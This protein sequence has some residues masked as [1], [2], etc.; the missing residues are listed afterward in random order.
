MLTSTGRKLGTILAAAIVTALVVAGCGGSDPAPTLAPIIVVPTA[1]TA[2]TAAPQIVIEKGEAPAAPKATPTPRI[3]TQLPT[4][5]PTPGLGSVT[6]VLKGFRWVQGPGVDSWR[7]A[8]KRGGTHTYAFPY[9]SGGT[10]QILSRSFTVA[11]AISSVYN[12]L[13]T[14]Q[15]SPLMVEGDP[16]NCFPVG[17]LISEWESNS[18]GTAWTLT[19]HP[20][21]KW[22]NFPE[23][24]RGYDAALTDLYGRDV[25]AADV[26]H[27]VHYMQGKLTKPN[28]EPQGTASSLQ[29]T[30][31]TAS[32]DVVDDKTV[33]FNLSSADPFFTSTW[34]EFNTK[35]M[36]PEIFNLDG[37]YTQRTVGS[38]PF[39]LTEWDRMVQWGGPANPNYHKVGA[40]GQSLP[41]IDR[42]QVKRLG[43]DLAISGFITGQVDNA[44]GVGVSGPSSALTFGR[45]CPNCQILEYF[46]SANTSRILG[47]KHTAT[48]RYP[49]PY[50][51]DRNARLAVAK[52]ID[53]KGIG[54]NLFEGAWVMTPVGLAWG[55]MWDQAA[56]PSLKQMGL[57]LPDD[58]NPFIYDPEK[59]KELWAQA[60]KSP[61]EKIQLMYHEYSATHT[62]YT[63]A[64]GASIAEALDI[65]VDV[66]KVPDISILYTATG[67]VDP[68]NQQN[69]EHLVTHTRSAG[70][71]NGVVP[72]T[73]M[74]NSVDNTF[75]FNNPKLDEIGAEWQGAP[76]PEREK[77]LARALYTEVVQDLIMMPAL[78]EA[79]YDVQSGRVRNSY[80]QLRGGRAFHQGGHLAEIIWFDD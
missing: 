35:I 26:V 69:H 2:P 41:Y 17:D 42:H 63:V 14:C 55:L 38:G 61:G 16:G 79:S 66:F 34:S 25:V 71:H 19:I 75:G 22:H 72:R 5:T 18:D 37:D 3:V 59:A 39:M 31:N 56:A 53:Y 6:E 27:S 29:F 46:L 4:S 43:T 32:V 65:E 13:F 73:F 50:F 44:L 49:D 76:S 21:A 58:E 52:A 7:Q 74:S 40:D 80:Q 47:F 33:R 30:A 78:T 62:T 77:E 54:D 70:S 48:D 20:D 1:E 8:P 67:F 23:D 11:T 12:K 9:P 15:F 24:G 60:G 28:G 36:P 64:L 51:G 57:D 45:N 68:A 10:D